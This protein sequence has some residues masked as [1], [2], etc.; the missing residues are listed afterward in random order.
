MGM[1]KAPL[2]YKAGGSDWEHRCQ[3]DILT[4]RR[5]LQTLSVGAVR[6]Y[7]ARASCTDSHCDWNARHKVVTVQEPERGRGT[8][9]YD[10][11]VKFPSRQRWTLMDFCLLG[12][13]VFILTVLVMRTY[14]FIHSSMLDRRALSRIFLTQNPLLP[15]DI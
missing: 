3:M 11:K 4:C 7:K 13:A 12:I 6:R 1:P 5:G 10:P 2:S 9:I 8:Y 14:P 15:T